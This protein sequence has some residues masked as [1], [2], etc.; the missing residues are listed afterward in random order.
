VER[1]VDE[2]V[3]EETAASTEAGVSCSVE[4]EVNLDETV[5]CLV[6]GFCGDVIVEVAVVV[7]VLAVEGVVLV[8]VV[9]SDDEVE[10]PVKG[11]T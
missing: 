5:V 10:G 6:L 11:T 1:T 7:V 2:M 8:A 3:E 9:T 4:V